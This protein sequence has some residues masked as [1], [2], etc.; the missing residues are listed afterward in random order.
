VSEGSTSEAT[1]SREFRNATVVPT[2]SLKAAID[3][4]DAGKLDAFATNK[5]T[6]FEMSDDLRGS[7]VLAGRW[8]L[9]SFAIGIPKGREAAMP[10]VSGF[11]GKAKTNGLV[12]RAV[13]R[14]GLRGTLAAN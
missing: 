6:L 3:M 7:R 10:L 2:A 5:A 1:L 9:E 11:V 13:E 8:G 14:A 12:T 4:L